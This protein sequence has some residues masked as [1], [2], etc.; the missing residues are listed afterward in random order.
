MVTVKEVSSKRELRAFVDFPNK[1]YRENPYFIPAIMSDDLEDANPKKNPAFEYCE[2]KYFLAY[3]DKEIVGRIAVILNRAANEKWGTNAVRFSQVDF[4]DDYEVSSALFKTA[5]DYA[6]S[7]GCAEVIGPLGCCDLDREGMLTRGYDQRDLFFTYYNFPYYNDHL[8]R[9]G[10]GCNFDWVE[11]KITIPQA[12]EPASERLDR[13]ANT[14]AR[15]FKLRIPEIKHTRDFY[16]YL[17]EIFKLL[18][19]C[20]AHLDG[21]VP[22]TDRQIMHYTKKYIGIIDPRFTCIIL[23]EK[24]EVIGFGI[25]VPSIDVALKKSRGRFLPFGWA[26][27]LKSLRKSDCLDL[28]LV[29]VA[30]EYQGTGANAML[31]NYVL[32]NAQK[33]GMKYAETGPQLVTNQIAQAQWKFFETDQHKGRRCYIKKLS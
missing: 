21:T 28:L 4:I 17:Q 15:R 33:M 25:S 7:M 19:I 22:L 20:Y 29:A 11:Y 30:P 13:L 18:N 12:G 5:E 14:V 8:E 31:I 10:Y 26:R 16:K 27:I 3:R 24:D 32:K 9:L 2:A 1:M 6:R 23:N